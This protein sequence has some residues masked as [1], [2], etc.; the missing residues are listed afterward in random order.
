MYLK[1]DGQYQMIKISEFN[2]I[3]MTP[4]DISLLPIL[5]EK[6]NQLEVMIF[7]TIFT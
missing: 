6:L 2:F 3:G 4:D 1:Y 5:M 7:N